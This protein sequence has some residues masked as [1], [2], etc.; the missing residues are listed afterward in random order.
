MVGSLAVGSTDEVLG[1]QGV[2]GQVNVSEGA[3]VLPGQ[4]VAGQET[5]LEGAVQIPGEETDQNEGEGGSNEVGGD[6]EKTLDVRPVKNVPQQL[7]VKGLLTRI[8]WKV[9][10]GKLPVGHKDY[11]KG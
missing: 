10:V 9:A 8:Y 6:G 1:G 7:L 5:A 2:A 4:E 3:Q 11:Q